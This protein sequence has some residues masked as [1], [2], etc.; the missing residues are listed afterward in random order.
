MYTE[1]MAPTE[2]TLVFVLGC[3]DAGRLTRITHGIGH[4]R[5]L[6]AL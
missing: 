5:E 3:L 1:A 4:G 2:A 6:L